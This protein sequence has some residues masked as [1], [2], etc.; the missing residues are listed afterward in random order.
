M[1]TIKYVAAATLLS[2]LSFGALA[3]QPA[4][5]TTQSTVKTSHVTDIEAGS[6]IAPGAQSTGRSMDDAFN[7]HTLV[8]GEWY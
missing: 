8:A 2:V 6:N 3:A 7:V 5:G 1:K 4:S